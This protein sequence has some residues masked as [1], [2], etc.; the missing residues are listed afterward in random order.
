MVKGSSQGGSSPLDPRVGFT[1]SAACRGPSSLDVLPCA[2]TTHAPAARSST[3]AAQRS[4]QRPRPHSGPQRPSSDSGGLCVRGPLDALRRRLRSVAVGCSVGNMWR[5]GSSEVRLTLDHRA[6]IA[7][8]AVRLGGPSRAS[9]YRGPWAHKRGPRAWCSPRG[10]GAGAHC[11]CGAAWPPGTR[12]SARFPQACVPLWLPPG[13][14][15][16]SNLVQSRQ[17]VPAP[18]APGAMAQ[19]RRGFLSATSVLHNKGGSIIG[20]PAAP[21]ARKGRQPEQRGR[22]NRG[23]PKVGVP[24]PQLPQA[25]VARL[26]RIRSCPNLCQHLLNS[27]SEP[28]LEGLLGTARSTS[29]KLGRS[30][31][32]FYQFWPV[33]CG[34]SFDQY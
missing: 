23:R 25:S 21:R 16:P 20:A 33:A 22:R 32:S 18:Q 15:A 9:Y 26:A 7:A 13:R 1:A 2:A 29:S 5:V 17:R 3:V 6:A 31:L 14:L 30:R 12:R 4:P 34:R 28:G 8:W 10:A 24:R 11:V 19:S 27:H